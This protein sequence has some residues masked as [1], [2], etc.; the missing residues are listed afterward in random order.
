MR[1]G[2]GKTRH[3]LKVKLKI[4]DTM[5]T[6][7]QIFKDDQFGQLRGM[8]INGEAWLMATD[9]ARKLGYTNPQKAIRDHID[10]EDKML[11]NSFTING[12]IPI[13]INESGFYSLI[14]TSK[15]PKARMFKRWVTTKVLPQ[16]RNTGGYIPLQ[17]EEDDKTILAKA[18]L[19]LNRTLTQKNELIKE[20]STKVEFAEAIIGSKGCIHISEL[21]KLLTQNGYEIGRTRLFRW[22][23]EN[24]YIFKHSTEPIQKWVEC[25]V[26]STSVT[27]INTNHGV[28]E[29][30]TTKV[31]GK[32]QQYFLNLFL[33]KTNN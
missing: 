3:I 31:T 22:L 1:I 5:N 24:G 30:I 4:L 15:L 27:L 16:I 20:Q 26:F 25:G 32:G 14:L 21:A 13:L 6:E 33:N 7:I 12:T 17:K 19:I 28:I 23:R 9:V 18:V 8:N 2:L 11:N 10:A 29:N